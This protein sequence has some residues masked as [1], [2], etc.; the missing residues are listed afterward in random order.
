MTIKTVKD[1]QNYLSTLDPETTILW[2]IKELSDGYYEERIED[3]VEVTL[4]VGVYSNSN[5][6]IKSLEDLRR[7]LFQKTLDN[8]FTDEIKEYKKTFTG[9][10][11]TPT[12]MKDCEEKIKK[13]KEDLQ[14]VID[15]A[16]LSE[17]GKSRKSLPIQDRL[18]SLGLLMGVIKSEAFKVEFE[19]KLLELKNSLKPYVLISPSNE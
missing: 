7:A 16:T 13:N 12:S 4:E 15:D 10:V 19:E 8:Y 9:W 1:L 2:K 11:F 3:S 6:D 5:S 17:F 14:K 18:R